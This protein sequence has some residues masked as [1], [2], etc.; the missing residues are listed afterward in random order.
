MPNAYPRLDPRNDLV[1]K[2]LFTA[3]P[4]LLADFINQLC[5]FPLP[6][7]QLEILNPHILP[8][9]IHAKFIVLDIRCRDSEGRLFDIEMQVRKQ[10]GYA[11]RS[12]Y[13]AARLLASQLLEGDAYHLLAP[14]I[15]IHLL[16][17]ELFPQRTHPVSHFQ[18]RCTD[19]PSLILGEEIQLYVLEMR[20]IQTHPLPGRLGEWI[21]FFEHTQEASAMNQLQHPP[22]QQA[23]AELDNLSMNSEA[24][25]RAFA[26]ERAIR[27]E[28]SALGEARREGRQT[29]QADLLLRQLTRRFG[30]LPTEISHRIQFA[31][32]TEIEEW[33]ERIL[34]ADSLT[35]VFQPH[36]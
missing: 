36:A 18:L 8:E 31:S 1:F 35:A 15:G 12:I 10:N 17:F 22:I 23:L 32:T 33:A 2:M 25:I 19:E 21:T 30:P 28:R 11:A 16:D 3:N 24:Q 26:R 34:E 20:K 27:D 13:Y 7:T 5:Q 29:G 4:L 6:V 9:D 14:A